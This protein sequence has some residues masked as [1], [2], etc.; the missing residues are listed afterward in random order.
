MIGGF[1]TQAGRFVNRA[2]CQRV[3]GLRRKQQI[4]NPHAV[5]G[6]QRIAGIVPESVADFMR[7]KRAESVKPAL[8]Q[9]GAEA[10]ADFAFHQRVGTEKF[11]IVNIGVG[12]NNIEI[13]AENHRPAAT[14][15]FPRML[16]ESVHPAQLIFKLRNVVRRIVRRIAV[17]QINRGDAD[18]AFAGFDVGFQI[19]GVFV[20]ET[21]KPLADNLYFSAAEHR[22]AVVAFLTEDFCL[23]TGHLQIPK[24]KALNSALISC[25]RTIS[26]RVSD[27]QAARFSMRALTEL[28]L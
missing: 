19:T 20:R 5:I 3:G 22:H 4:V 25:R 2:E 24:G 26:G 15:K 11:R 28:T 14:E 7:M 10:F 18:R 8:I 12:K 13:A 17:R 27:S 21:G 16:Q 9:Q 23:I 6:I 1:Y